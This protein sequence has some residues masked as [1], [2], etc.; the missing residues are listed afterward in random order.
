MTCSCPNVDALFGSSM[1]CETWAPAVIV[2]G[3]RRGG[4]S[5]RSSIECAPG[6]SGTVTGVT[7]RSTPS[8]NSFAPGG[9]EFI[10]SM[11]S[12]V[13]AAGEM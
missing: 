1:Y 13:V 3:I 6:F 11:P 4:P 7:P 2:I 5:P 9:F 8:T 10:T 12:V